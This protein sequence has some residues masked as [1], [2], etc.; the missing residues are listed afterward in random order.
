VNQRQK[1]CSEFEC[2]FSFD[3]TSTCYTTVHVRSNGNIGE[4]DVLSNASRPTLRNR[5][6]GSNVT[7]SSPTQPKKQRRPII[8]TDDG[9]RMAVNPVP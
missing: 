5:D 8:S 7:D 3:L 1:R 4:T 6:P 2:P 9:I